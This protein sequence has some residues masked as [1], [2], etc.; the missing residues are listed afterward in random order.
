METDA[1]KIIYEYFRLALKDL[2]GNKKKTGLSVK[3]IAH[4]LG[5]T[6]PRI[7]MMHKE[8]TPKPANFEQQVKI[9]SIAGMSYED[10]LAHGKAIKQ[11][12]LA[13]TPPVVYPS[14]SAPAHNNTSTQHLA[15]LITLLEKHINEQSA[16]MTGLEKRLDEQKARVDDLASHVNAL[17]E[18]VSEGF[19]AVHK[20]ISVMQTETEEMRSA[21][22]EVGRTKDLAILGM[23]GGKG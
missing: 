18:S 22:K 17:S 14:P 15:D 2:I 5:V 3:M 13:F 8:N 6:S 20:Q 21:L 7:S 9:A 10:F 23:I 4:E 11:K 1:P 19:P 16:R 12:G